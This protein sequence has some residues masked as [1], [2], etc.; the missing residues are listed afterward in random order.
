MNNRNFTM[1]GN[2][3]AP[4]KHMYDMILCALLLFERGYIGRSGGAGGPD[5]WMEIAIRLYR[6]I[7]EKDCSAEIYLPWQ[8]FNGKNS[9]D[10]ELKEHYISAKNLPNTDQAHGIASSVVDH[11]DELEEGSG[12]RALH[13]RNPYQVLGKRLNK[14]SKLLVCS[15]I[16][17]DAH[18]GVKG[19]TGGT[20]R[21][22]LQHGV[23]VINVALKKD[24]EKLR[25]FNE[26]NLSLLPEE[27]RE[28]VISAMEDY[29]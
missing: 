27:V 17:T 3:K 29:K 8:N 23:K 2:R 21:L 10:H 4:N 24:L 16:P 9:F 28:R 1:V 22:A 5:D 14:P 12:G 26:K 15:A 7:F 25:K 13:G 19:G 20:V 11:W 18:G 6:E